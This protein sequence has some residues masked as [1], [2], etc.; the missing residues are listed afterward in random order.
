M[1]RYDFDLLR[2]LHRENVAG[3]V[4]ARRRCAYS[5]RPP[6]P[7]LDVRGG[8]T[9]QALRSELTLCLMKGHLGADAPPSSQD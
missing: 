5:G 3:H 6:S 9:S 7:G 2:E 1:R 4:L 8:S